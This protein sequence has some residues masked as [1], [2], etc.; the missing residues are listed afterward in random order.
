MDGVQENAPPDVPKGASDSAANGFFTPTGKVAVRGG[1]QTK[2]TH[3]LANK[4]LYLR[5]YTAVG[6]I[7]VAHTDGST[8]HK[9]IR[10]TTDIAFF[11]GVEATST[12]DLVWNSA[13]VA[14]PHAAELFERLYV[15]DATTTYAN[16]HP[17]K[18]VDANGVV[19]SVSHDLGGGAQAM[20]P[21]VVEEYNSH[22]FTAGY[23]NA[24]LSDDAPHMVRHSL[25]GTAPDAAGGFDAD[26]YLVLGARG[27]RVTGL[28]KGRGLLLAAKAG[29]MFRI[30]GFGRGLPGWQFQ[31][32]QVNNT[33]GMG[34]SN[35]LALTFAGDYWYGLGES[36][37]FRTNGFDVE[38]LVGA[39][40]R[41]WAKVT[42]LAYSWVTYHPDRDCVL[43]GVNQTPVPS[44]RSATYP[45]T[46]WVWDCQR[47]VWAGDI[48]CS[49]DIHYAHAIPTNTVQGPT[50]APSSL[51]VTHASA[52]LTTVAIT[53][54]NG[55]SSAAT[56]IWVRNVTDGGSSA[57]HQTAAAGA[58]SATVTGLSQGKKYAV[59]VRH[60][61]SSITTDFTAESDAFTL[62]PAPGLA[63]V[64]AG[65]AVDLTASVAVATA[66]RVY[67]ERVTTP[68]ND[69][70]VTA[71]GEY[72][73]EDTG[74]TVNTN[75]D[76]RARI[77]S[78]NWPAAI[79][80][81]AYTSITV[82]TGDAV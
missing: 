77:R 40:K 46:I 25:L 10:L 50:A 38:S 51:A 31:V 45:T 22:L 26:A 62:L 21:Y 74:L 29:E 68:I 11:T 78:T 27:Q 53:W 71:A 23:D 67:F 41:S 15:A 55:D 42:N 66:T 81:S 70:A 14:R 56:E 16:R 72:I 65:T 30:S 8:L 44:G 13:N 32:E 28:K 82:N 73:Y 9:L 80:Y 75:Y 33:L 57:L 4:V 35:P 20:K 2:L 3:T 76:Y 39:R 58:T 34:V 54:A 79:E 37:P 64:G 59:K 47:E 17:L 69:Q 18:V 6:A 48:S 43:F 52:A 24:T 12:H 36:G 61:K 49:A 19:A 63:G 7:A 60:N 5:P 1:S